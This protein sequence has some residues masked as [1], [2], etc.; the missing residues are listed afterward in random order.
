MAERTKIKMFWKQFAKA[1]VASL[2]LIL[3]LIYSAP[4]QT[5]SKT[6]RKKATVTTVKPTTI[7][8]PTDIPAKLPP[9]KNGRPEDISAIADAPQK[10]TATS[11]SI[12]PTYF[13]EFSQPDFVI[14]RIL[15]EHDEAGKGKLSFMKKGYSELVSDPVEVSPTAMERINNAL[16]ALNFLDS[17]ENYQYEKDFAHLG[18]MSFRLKKEGRERTA[19]F[20][21]TRI[22]QV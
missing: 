5:K 4:A 3:A 17:N 11:N 9:K 8:V 15:I 12:I 10:N 7:V 18:T 14:E 22:H 6:P 2:S 13:Y 21:R 20:S 1:L 19:T 16:A